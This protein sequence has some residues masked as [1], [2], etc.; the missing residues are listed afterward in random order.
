MY[1]NKNK[2]TREL[3][4][5]KNSHTRYLCVPV[6]CLH[7][8]FNFLN[9]FPTDLMALVLFLRWFHTNGRTV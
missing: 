5:I 3:K 8:Q 4:D 1:F 9:N 2:I 7:V 6:A